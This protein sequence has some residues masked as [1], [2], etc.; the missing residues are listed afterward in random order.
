MVYTIRSLL[1]TSI[2]EASVHIINVS[3]EMEHARV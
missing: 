1:E 3:S 2:W